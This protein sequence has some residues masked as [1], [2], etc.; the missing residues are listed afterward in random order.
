MNRS[1]I[2]VSGIASKYAGIRFVS[3]S[4]CFVPFVSPGFSAAKR[5]VS[6]LSW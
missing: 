3:V 1:V 4:R 6:V 5:F 2:S